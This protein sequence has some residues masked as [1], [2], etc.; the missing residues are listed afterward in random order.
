MGNPHAVFFVT[1]LE[2]VDAADLGAK[3]EVHPMF[4]EKA[5]VTFARV[6]ARD[7]VTARVWE[8]GVG[9]T[10]ACGSAACATLVAGVAP[11]LDGSQGNRAPARRRPRD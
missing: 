5:N 8:R 7:D 1:D 6:N 9:L 11:G 4:P 2:L 10:L 3:I